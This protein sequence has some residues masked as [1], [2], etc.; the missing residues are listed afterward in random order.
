MK[1]KE[2]KPPGKFRKSTETVI[3]KNFNRREIKGSIPR[4]QR[5]RK[6]I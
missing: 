4:T 3:K 6:V 1:G 5:R 2:K